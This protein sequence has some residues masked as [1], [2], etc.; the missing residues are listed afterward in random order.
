MQG[1]LRVVLYLEDLGI[2]TM[3]EQKKQAQEASSARPGAAFNAAS[4]GGQGTSA[5]GN[6][7]EE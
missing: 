3:E 1:L 6:P 2:A 7:V 4:A 5:N